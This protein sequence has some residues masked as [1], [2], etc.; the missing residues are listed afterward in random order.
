M[1]RWIRWLSVLLAIQVVLAIGLQISS[2]RLSAAPVAGA[3]LLSSS[4]DGADHLTIEGPDGAKVE[5][6]RRAGTWQLPQEA[7]F[8]ADEGKIKQLLTHM[9][10]VKTGAA[11]SKTHSSLQRFKVADDNFERRVTLAAGKKILARIY[12]GDSPSPRQV[13]LRRDG[14][15][16]VYDVDLGT[17]QFPADPADW[18][19]KAILHVP[20]RSIQSIEVDGLTLTH[21]APTATTAATVAKPAA[22]QHA[23]VWQAKGL[24][25]GEELDSTAATTLAQRLSSLDIGSVLGRENRS[26]Y[27]LARPAL[28]FAITRDDGHRIE[29]RLGR[30][31]KGGDYVIKSSAHAE[32]FR[33]PAGTANELIDAARRDALVPA[34][35]GHKKAG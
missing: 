4:T 14:K 11:V 15:D 20:Q 16:A 9:A 12:L 21:A 26:D 6:V 2:S 18:E 1:K 29:Y 8:P 24:R 10:S 28:Q 32:Y 19:D 3:P 27:G 13:H 30:M 31:S 23:D 22:T 7:D 17:W 33:I 25:K 34:A 35:K 5:L